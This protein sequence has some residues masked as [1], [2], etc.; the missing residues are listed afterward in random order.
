MTLLCQIEACLNSRP[1]GPLSLEPLDFEYLTPEHFLIGA[2]LIAIPE[3]SLLELNETRLNRWQ[4]VQR[5][6]ERF[7]RLWSTDYLLQLQQRHSW[8][9]PCKNIEVGELVLLRN[10]NLPP[11]KWELGRV[12]ESHPGKDGLVRVVTVRT[13]TTT[14]KRPIAKLCRLPIRAPPNN[15][16]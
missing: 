3:P 15:V 16:I 8:P 4:L 7:W 10:D 13:A 9:K 5:M 2:P 12:I 1:L 14:Y 11:S 6:R